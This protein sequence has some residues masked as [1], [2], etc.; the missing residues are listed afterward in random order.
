MVLLRGLQ[1]FVLWLNP[2][3]RLVDV[4]RDVHPRQ[5][6]LTGL[7]LSLFSRLSPSHKREVLRAGIAEGFILHH[8]S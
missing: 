1:R 7:N 3:A 4:A 5:Y 8:L 2:V 6:A